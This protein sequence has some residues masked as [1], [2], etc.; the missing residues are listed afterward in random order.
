V[1][2]QLNAIAGV[3]SSSA[4]LADNGNRMVRIMIRP[5]ANANHVM[6][7][8]QRTLR[9]AVPNQTPARV[10]DKSA[11]ALGPQQAWLTTSQL[12]ALATIEESPPRQSHLGYWL[13]AL[14][15]LIALGVFLCWRLRHQ[16]NGCAQPAA[17]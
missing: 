17:S 7:E 16:R 8:V 12:N 5:G 10:K 3:Q 2:T 14:S 11:A 4:L 1:L 9:A 13:L 15:V 6:E